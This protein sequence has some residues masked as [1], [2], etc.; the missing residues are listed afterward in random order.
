MTFSD[1]QKAAL[2]TAL[3]PDQGKN[4]YYPTLGLTGEAG[5]VANKVK[6]VMRDSGGHVS[7]EVRAQ[8]SQELGDV[9]WYVSG[10]AN[11][12]G[13][14]LDEIADANIEKLASRAQRKVLGRSGDKR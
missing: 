13:L 4:L 1:Y 9:L 11:E 6:K 8:L 5:E 7:A 12:L 14:N 10:V 3:Y 2:K